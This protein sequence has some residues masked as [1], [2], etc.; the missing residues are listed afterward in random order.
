MSFYVATLFGLSW[1]HFP[2]FYAR[3]LIGAAIA[4]LATIAIFEHGKWRLGLVVRPWIAARE[5][6]EGLA[7]GGMLVGSCALIV[8]LSTDVRHEPGAGFPWRELLIVFIPAVLHEELL[9]RGY[10]YQ[11]LRTWSRPFALVFVALVFAALHAN[12]FAVTW[13]A[14]VNIFLGGVLLGLAYEVYERLWLPIGLHLAW[15]LM[16]GP[17]LGHEVSGYAGAATLFVERGSGPDLLTGGA[18]GIEG[19]VLM[20]GMELLAL[21]LFWKRLTKNERSY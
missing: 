17:I 19:S 8:V 11:K 13:L 15:N 9:F 1:L 10:P 20:T 2:F 12:N 14:L 7:W 5:L 21:A 3:G 6:L 16:S 18:F 4:T